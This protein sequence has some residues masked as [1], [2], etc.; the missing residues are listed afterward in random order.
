MPGLSLAEESASTV[1]PANPVWAYDS[2][3]N[4]CPDG[5]QPVTNGDGVGCGVPNQAVSYQVATR[6]HAPRR[7]SGV[8]CPVGEKGCYTR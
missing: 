4:H 1:L 5:M 6:S 3:E 2:A 7:G 8:V